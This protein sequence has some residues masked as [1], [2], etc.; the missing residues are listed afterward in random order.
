MRRCHAIVSRV[1]RRVFP[2]HEARIL[3]WALGLVL[4][5]AALLAGDPAIVFVSRTLNQPPNP[6]SRQTAVE[7]ARSGKLVVKDA[8]GTQDIVTT[9]NEL[10]IIDVMDPEVSYDGKTIIFA[11]YNRDNRGFRIYEIGVD[12]TGLRQVTTNDRQIDL[13]R[14]GEAAERFTNY[15]DFDPCYLPDGRICFVSTRYPGIAPDGRVLATNLYVVNADSSDAHRITSER[16]GADTPTVHPRTGQIT[17]SRF[18]RTAQVNTTPGDTKPVEEIPPGSPGYGS[19]VPPTQEDGPPAP[20]LRGIAE[21]E[22]P[23]VNNWF[24]ATINPDGTGV[25]MASGFRLDRQLTQAW[26][27]SYLADG[28]VLALFI[29]QTPMQGY[30]GANGLRLFQHGPSAPEFLGGPQTFPGSAGFP[31]GPDG[32]PVPP[33]DPA[34]APF[35]YASAV[36]LDDGRFLVTGVMA[37]SQDHDVF[38][39]SAPNAIPQPYVQRA[40]TSELDA[41]V[42]AS[43]PPPEESI[44]EVATGR[45]LD[46]APATIEDAKRDGGTFTFVC[47]NIFFNAPVDSPI[48]NAP[49][50]G[51]SLAIEFF[52]APQRTGVTSADPPISI[53]LQPIGPEGKIEQEL[54]GGVPLFEVLRRTDGSVPVGRDGQIFHVG[55]MNFNRSGSGG[56]CVGC[57]AGHSMIAVPDDPSWTNLGPS[58]MVSASSSRPTSRENGFIALL[59]PSAV[60]DRRTDAV[61]SEWAAAPIQGDGAFLELQWP[62]PIKAREI[63][64]H[65]IRQNPQVGTRTTEIRKVTVITQLVGER[66]GEESEGL[67]PVHRADS[68]SLAVG[69]R[70]AVSLDPEKPFDTLRLEFASVDVNGSFLGDRVAALAEVEVIAKMAGDSAPVVSFVRGDVN[71]DGELNI[72]DA[73]TALNHLFL[74]GGRLCCGTAADANDDSVINMT[75]PVATL[76]YLFLGRDPLPAPSTFGGRGAEGPFICETEVDRLEPVPLAAP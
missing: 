47:D 21:D 4:V 72:T 14:Y 74:E 18:W 48:P 67:P 23:G 76:G 62:V 39:Q 54:P 5:Q 6:A 51:R 50:I 31:G 2:H 8:A 66:S 30:P 26:R 43:R 11:G 24:L 7:R 15:D 75:D 55:G 1:C 57:H 25:A 10:G 52:M 61:S 44:P 42:L 27:P 19:V 68:P 36:P 45:L 56:S 41:V 71:C 9:G 46:D 63:V 13:A 58:A 38:I 69:G 32:M 28:R 33:L 34:V 22:F 20:V 40:G 35:F 70:V 53:A 65:G 49:P 29:P 16:F 37:G 73:V 17:Y 60:V 12:G 59:S 3:P 64:L